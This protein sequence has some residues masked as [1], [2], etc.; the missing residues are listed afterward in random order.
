[1]ALDYII[2][3]PTSVNA[4][5]NTMHHQGQLAILRHYAGEKKDTWR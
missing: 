2:T 4:A 1:M 5:P 3:E